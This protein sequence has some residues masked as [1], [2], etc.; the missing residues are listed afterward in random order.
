MRTPWAIL[1]CKFR[2]DG[3]A[4][5]GNDLAEP[6]S[7]NAY[8]QFFTPQNPPIQNV[9]HY[10]QAASF[11]TIQLDGTQVFGWFTLP[12]TQG[13]YSDRVRANRDAGRQE[14][15]DLA[16]Q[17]AQAAGHNLDAFFGVVVHMNVPTDLFGSPGQV[18]CDGNALTPELLG[19]EMGHGYGLA[20]SRVLGSTQDYQDMWDI[21]S[22]MNTHAYSLP[23]GNGARIGPLL[24]TANARE[25]GWL[26]EERIWKGNAEGF[27]TEI[28][29]RAL[30]RYTETGY[31][32]AQIPDGT[33]IE[34]RNKEGWDLGI[35]ES[36]VLIHHFESGHSYLHPNIV[37]ANGSSSVNGYR[38]GEIYRNEVLG[39][40]LTTVQVLRIDSANGIARVRL[41]FSPK[42]HASLGVFYKRQ[43]NWLTWRAFAG[44]RWHAPEIFN[45]R[46]SFPSQMTSSP[47]VI[48]GWRENRFAVFF[49]GADQLLRWKAHSGG[50]WHND[51]IVSPGSVLTSE[52]CMVREGVDSLAAFYRTS[53]DSLAWRLYA[54]GRWHGEQIFN[55]GATATRMASA[56][57]AVV[58]WRGHRYAVFFTGMDGTL[59]W[60]AFHGGR[61]HGDAPVEGGR[62]LTSAP[63]VLAFGADELAVF[64]KGP[65][66]ELVWRAYSQG[67]WHA[68]EVFANGHPYPTQMDS[69]PS[70]VAG[71][72]GSK[73]AVFFRGPDGRLRWK[74]HSGGRWHA[75]A[76]IEGS[77][78]LGSDPA[79]I[80]FT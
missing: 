16:R 80:R 58:N 71:F 50:R 25:M 18:L 7:R 65:S 69:G 61:W 48:E 53:G 29:L 68:E 73:F 44:G 66:Q 55:T 8:I 5:N 43:D 6:M 24:T 47:S 3:N 19:H 27:S 30:S 38:Q 79:A 70:V 4:S 34:F 54:E 77:D 41:G 37:N 45:N 46:H 56:P 74:A 52:P 60:K 51:A 57:S 63:K 76:A 32:A 14:A 28:E 67:R 35:P 62:R 40:G 26:N 2:D 33:L 23:N 31:L 1:L 11:G 21:M 59:R 10:F 72:Q 9:A 15:V 12:L 75:D 78:L 49:R 64:Y 22:A 36:V 39:K 20:H 42:N 17:V 13:Q